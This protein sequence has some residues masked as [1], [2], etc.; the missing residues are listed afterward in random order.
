MLNV[1]ECFL[2]SFI[3]INIDLLICYKESGDIS[4]CL[5]SIIHSSPLIFIF[6]HLS[7]YL[8]ASLLC[9]SFSSLYDCLMEHIH[10]CIKL[11]SLDIYKYFP[12][13]ALYLCCSLRWRT[14]LLCLVSSYF[15]SSLWMLG[16]QLWCGF[17][18]VSPETIFNT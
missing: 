7:I 15:Q 18:L 8:F 2:A 9:Q 12:K 5:L 4:I 3:W 10:Y 1:S 11:F 17:C 13:N 6:I 14:W 16:S